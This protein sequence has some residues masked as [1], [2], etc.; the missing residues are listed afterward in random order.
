MKAKWYQA[1]RRTLVGVTLLVIAAG[2]AG[3]ERARLDALLISEAQALRSDYALPGMTVAVAGPTGVTSIAVGLA[4]GQTGRAMDAATTMLAA[5]IGKTFVAATVLRLSEAGR[6]TL[7]DPISRWLGDRDWFARLPNGESITIRQLLR[8]QSGLP[9][10]VQLESFARLWPDRIATT[11]PEELIALTFDEAPLFPPGQG[12][13]YSDT[14]YLLLGLVIEAVTERSYEAIVREW[15]L[16]PLSL[17][18]T[19]PSNR[20]DLPGLAQG[21]V[22]G[23]GGLGLPERTLDQTGTLLWDPGVEWTGGGFYST[24]HD[25]AVWGRAFLSGRLLADESY[26]AATAGVS[27]G[28]NDPSSRYGLGIAIRLQTDFGPVYGHR[29]W[30]PGYVSSL[31][32]YPDYDLAVAFMVNTDVGI[33]DTEQ[34]VIMEMEERLIRLLADD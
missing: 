20:R 30:I 8:H 2:A 6:L 25:L 34:P 12:W 29:G 23:G 26:G 33:I 16:E 3:A 4:D 19:G 13:S 11:G 28:S 27:T 10:H 21:V 24:A 14:G 32:Y 22:A 31:Q 17:T 18:A 7:D 15:F 9:D 1:A 5:S